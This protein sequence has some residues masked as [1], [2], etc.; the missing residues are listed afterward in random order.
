MTN[1]IQLLEES[2]EKILAEANGALR[3]RRLKHYEEAGTKQR[4]ES[5]GKLYALVCQSVKHKNLEPLIDYAERIAQEKFTAG[6]DLYEV[7]TTFN[8]LEEAVWKQIIQVL[9]TSELAEALGLITTALGAG[10]DALART[11]VSLASKARAPS[12]DL[13]ELFKGT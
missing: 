11:Y 12:L 9:P 1:L 8:V 4:E 7:Q 13:S 6:F 10:K 5:L 3:R 2:S